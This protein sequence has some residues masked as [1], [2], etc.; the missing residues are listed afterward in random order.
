MN[1]KFVYQIG[2]NKKVMLP[3]LDLVAVPRFVRL[4][5]LPHFLSPS[6]RETANFYTP[7]F[8]ECSSKQ[9]QQFRVLSQTGAISMNLKP[10]QVPLHH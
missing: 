5:A 2:N 9:L 1:K 7:P 10:C 8:P 4:T 3:N 6:K